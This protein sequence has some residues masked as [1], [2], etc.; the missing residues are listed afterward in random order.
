MKQPCKCGRRWYANHNANRRGFV[1]TCPSCHRPAG[2]CEC[3]PVE[4]SAER[5]RLDR[6]TAEPCE[7]TF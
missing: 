6:E 2:Q 7:V 4:D 5:E 3:E 1:P